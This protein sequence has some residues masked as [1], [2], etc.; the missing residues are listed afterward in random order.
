MYRFWQTILLDEHTY[1]GAPFPPHARM[2]LEQ[3][4]FDSRSMAR[5][6]LCN[7]FYGSLA[8]VQSSGNQCFPRTGNR[9]TCFQCVK[10]SRMELVKVATLVF[11]L[12][13]MI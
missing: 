5:L 11:I 12:V 6:C 1:Y 3:H 2:P 4:H 9:K 13:K 7:Q 8:E 10:Q